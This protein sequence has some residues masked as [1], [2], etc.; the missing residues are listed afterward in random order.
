MWTFRRYQFPSSCTHRGIKA[1]NNSGDGWMEYFISEVGI[2]IAIGLK[3]REVPTLIT[4]Y[5]YCSNP[6]ES[7]TLAINASWILPN[8]SNQKYHVPWVKHFR[9]IRTKPTSLYSP[10]CPPSNEL[11]Y[12]SLSLTP[13]LLQLA[14]LGMYLLAVCINWKK[15]I[16]SKR[17]LVED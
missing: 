13:L 15:E 11:N 4:Y 7:C 12:M 10:C 8:G 5:E 9:D 16:S 6:S 1:R 14:Q 2:G 17:R 3:L